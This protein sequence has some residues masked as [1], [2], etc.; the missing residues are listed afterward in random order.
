M[1][2]LFLFH[3]Y[4]STY[5]SILYMYMYKYFFQQITCNTLIYPYNCVAVKIRMFLAQIY[6]LLT[7]DKKLKILSSDLKFLISNHRTTHDQIY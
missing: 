7:D 3:I 4:T 1:S 6:F 5:M 2:E